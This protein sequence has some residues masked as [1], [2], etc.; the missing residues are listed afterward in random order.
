[1]KLDNPFP[2]LGRVLGRTV[3]AAGLC[4]VVV[5]TG[6]ARTAAA[7]CFGKP[8]TIQGGAKDDTIEGTSGSDVISAGDGNDRVYGNGGDDVICGDAGNDFIQTFTGN[9]RLDG[10][11]GDDQ[12]VGGQGNDELNGGANTPIGD[13]AVFYNAPAAVTVFLGDGSATGAGSDRLVGIEGLYGSQ[14]DDTLVGTPADEFFIPSD[15]NDQVRGGGGLDAALFYSPVQVNLAAHRATGEG[16]DTL[17]QI[18][19]VVGSDAADTITGD[20]GMNFLFGAAGTDTI[21]GGAGR[22]L[23]AGDFE[24]SPP[25]GNDVLSGGPGDDVLVG[26]GGDDVLDGGAGLQDVA[27]FWYSNGASVNLATGQAT[28][29]QEGSDRLRRIEG[30]WGSPGNDRIVGSGRSDFLSGEAGNDT[31]SGGGADDYL[32]GGAG[33]D[34]T[35][36]GKGRDYCVHGE[37]RLSC[38]IVGLTLAASRTG[39]A[40][41]L[42]E[43]QYGQHPTCVSTVVKASSLGERRKPRRRH[44]SSIAPPD[45]VVPPVHRRMPEFPSVLPVGLDRVALVRGALGSAAAAD[46]VTWQPILYRYNPRLRKY[47]VIKRGPVLTTHLSANGV[48]LWSTSGGRSVTGVLA[49][50]PQ[51]GRY[52]W[53]ARVHFGTGE[54]RLDTVEPHVNYG[55]RARGLMQQSC[56]F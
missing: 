37:S 19:A 8:V 49:K 40:V 45:R 21:N 47:R 25:F 36:G 48:T 10:G 55:T 30:V 41:D 3:L 53:K 43:V 39:A 7:T 44:T 31:V 32:D 34:S 35:N 14:H 5:Q 33:D 56:R 16:T 1:M 42:G 24:G 26:V 11:E 38:E 29:A 50:I 18:N 20:S 46:L 54:T 27:A 12:L 13:T 17:S 28:S 15:G 51:A 6:S 22:D 2:R 23:L 4:L 9:D 52:A